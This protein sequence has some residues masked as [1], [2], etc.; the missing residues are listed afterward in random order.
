MD[1]KGM[2]TISY[3]SAVLRACMYMTIRQGNMGFIIVVIL[4]CQLI[5]FFH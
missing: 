2:E 1:M 4:L 5:R 3:G